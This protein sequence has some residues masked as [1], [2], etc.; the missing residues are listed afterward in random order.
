MRYLV[1]APAV[2][3]CAGSFLAFAA[4]NTPVNE[5]PTIIEEIVA[6]VN[7]EIITKGDL[8]RAEHDL[9]ADLHHQ[10][11][12]GAEYEKAYEQNKNDI[13]RNKIDQALLVQKGKD[14]DINVDSD[15]S[16][17]LAELQK[18][19][20]IADPDKFHEYVRQQTN[21]PYEDFV[22]QAKDGIITQRVIRQEVGSR[23]VVKHE[24]IEKYYN[25][26]KSEF[27]RK[28]QVFLREILVSTNGKNATSM[29]AALKKAKDLATRAKNG[30]RFADLAKD[31]SDAVT[32]QAGGDLGG[33]SN[34][35]LAKKIEDAVWNQPRGYV[36]DPIQVDN[37]YLILKVEDHQ[38]A[39]QAT[40]DEVSN[41]IMEKLFT[42]K[43]QPA[44]REYLTKLRTQAFLEIKPGYTDTG[45]APGM[46]TTWV[47]TAQLKPET[48]TKEEVANQK[49]H[50][51]LLGVLPVPGT[52]ATSSSKSAK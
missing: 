25:E 39:G 31:N 23:I 24:D 3:V 22:Q 41:E 29:D 38:K 16:K 19:S 28:E 45:A 44:V 49:R 48:V 12:S 35:Q 2:V 40:L 37:G 9:S 30:E 43:M 42:P 21:M 33:W 10:G 4:D 52:T 7:G 34:G 1:L 50:K 32:A 20:G 13:L 18:N 17:Y 5:T 11:L 36:T 8:A 27:I 14:L 51:R 46:D 47:A 26:H 6:K 15:L